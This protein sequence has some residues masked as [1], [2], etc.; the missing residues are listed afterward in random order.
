MLL[1]GK[2]ALVTG[3]ANR[4]GAEIARTLHQNGANLIIHYRNSSAAAHAL[5]R[6][7]NAE[8][9]D[10]AICYQADLSDIEALDLL[11]QKSTQAFDSLDFL[12]NNASCFYP[13]RLGEINQRDWQDLIG[14]NFK[15]PLFLSQACYPSLREANGAIVN[16]LDIYASSPLKNYSL[17][18]C[19][20][21][22][23]QMLVK[24]L[25]LEMAPQVR[26]NGIAPG[27]ILWPE[28]SDANAVEKQQALLRKIPLNRTGS[29]ESITQTVMFLL[30]HDYITGEVIRVDGG[31]LLHSA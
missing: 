6:D 3:A 7:L 19:T 21:A 25:A 30:G 8:R 1:A 24:S 31:R 14:S 5:E 16:M 12:I 11:A 28:T 26:V 15:A 13:T 22:A 20:K 9:N 10:S 29:T 23:S 4:I 17:Y 18:C 27:A 2:T